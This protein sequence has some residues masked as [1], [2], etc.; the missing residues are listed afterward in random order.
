MLKKTLLAN[1]LSTFS[2]KGNPVFSNGHKRLS[3][4]LPDC[5]ILCNWIFDSSLLAKELFAKALQ[6]FETCVLVNNKLC[7]ILFSSL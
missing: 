3:K 1:G 2:V 7:G 6:G 4:N 5:P